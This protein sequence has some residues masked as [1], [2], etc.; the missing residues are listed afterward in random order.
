MKY[1]DGVLG[2]SILIFYL[3]TGS[4]GII[5]FEFSTLI[6]LAIGLIIVVYWRD[7]NFL[8]F[9]D[10]DYSIG[11]KRNSRNLVVEPNNVIDWLQK[12]KI[13]ENPAYRLMDLDTT[14]DSNKKIFTRRQKV[15]ENGEEKIK[16]GVIA[17]PRN[18]M[19][20]E[21]IAYV[22]HCDEG[23]IEYS[24]NLHT[25]DDRLDPFNGRHQWMQ[26]AGYKANLESDEQTVSRPGSVE[27]YQGNSGFEG[28]KE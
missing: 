22:V 15:N 8:G 16:Y 4:L 19:D 5:P 6:V 7:P 23:D 27:I 28:E 10:G 2:L 12:E 11:G 18:M 17:R 21:M 14:K 20:R 9:L 13:P 26:N 25:S 24:G 1:R 3:I